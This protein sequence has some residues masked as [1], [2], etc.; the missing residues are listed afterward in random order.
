MRGDVD[1]FDDFDDVSDYDEEEP[2]PPPR[3]PRRKRWPFVMVGVVLLVVAA[4]FGA[5]QQLGYGFYSDYTGDG[6][7]DVLFQVNSGDTVRDMAANMA[8][9]GI[10]AS[11]NA[12]VKAARG[13]SKV[14][15]VQP[16]YYVLE[17]KMS[18]ASAVAKLVDTASKVG[19]LQIQAGWQLD[20][21]TS[22]SGKVTKGILSHIASATCATLNGRSTCLSVQDLQNAVQNTDPAA[23]GVPNWAVAALSNVDPKHRLEG[24]IL[25]GVYQLKPGETAVQT[26]NRLLAASVATLQEAG[27]PSS[28]Q[29]NSGF[30][31]Y[32][33]L[34][35]ASIIEREAG[36]QA[37][38]PKIARVLYNRLALPMDLQLDST[39]DYALDRPMIATSPSERPGAGLY[40]TYDNPGLPPTPISSPSLT[41]I[42]AA[43]SPTAGPW[44]F[45]VVC[46]K[47]LSSCFATTFAQHQANVAIAHNN[48][49]F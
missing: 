40:D 48:G 12:F 14:A 11:A 29:Q 10:V 25:P 8:Q 1:V 9:A 16:G 38:M 26:I 17:E 20:D 18:S 47:N 21:T 27:L 41:A 30:S 32:Q 39:V 28:T 34:T 7:G 3:R 33:V 42:Q 24:L 44:L 13:S 35:M 36:T 5:A 23:L 22:T 4:V 46:Q 2:S 43:I 49:V 45:F 15:A 6:S 37:D 31:T 19:E